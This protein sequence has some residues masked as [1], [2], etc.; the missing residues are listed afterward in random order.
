MAVPTQT[1]PAI[2]QPNSTEDA[3]VLACITELR[4][5][6]TGAVD[7]TNLAAAAQPNNSVYKTIYTG[8]FP[9]MN[10]AVGTTK[11]ILA[12][13][14]GQANT[15]AAASPPLTPLYLVAADYAITGLTTKIRIRLIYASNAT[16]CAT[17]MTAAFTPLTV[18]GGAGVIGYTAGA[19]VVTAAV[20]TPGASAATIATS[21]DATIP[22]DGLYGLTIV[23]E[24]LCNFKCVIPNESASGTT[25]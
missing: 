17:T 23:V 16:A 25:S 19:D 14:N 4:G 12:A 9:S 1:L 15:T 3:K 13:N 7:A 21:T 10:N 20:V 18:A 2:G 11:L 6:L 22:A 5:I 8:S 24:S